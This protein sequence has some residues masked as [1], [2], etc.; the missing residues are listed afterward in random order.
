LSPDDPWRVDR[1]RQL[2]NIEFAAGHLEAAIDACHK[3]LDAGDRSQWLYLSLAAA[4]ALQGK[5]DERSGTW[6]KPFASIRTSP[7]N[8]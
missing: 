7:S 2:G 6:P 1:D 3:A 8:G 4:Y 5:M